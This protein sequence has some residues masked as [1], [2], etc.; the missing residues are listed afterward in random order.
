MNPSAASSFAEHF[1]DLLDKILATH[2][3]A[4]SPAGLSNSALIYCCL[5]PS[6]IKLASFLSQRVL[7]TLMKLKRFHGAS[8][9]YGIK[10]WIKRKSF[11]SSPDGWPKS[12]HSPLAMASSV[13]GFRPVADYPVHPVNPV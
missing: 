4:F 1:L 2:S 13:S 3:H 8:R 12:Y 5:N 10:R 6:R 11:S 9:I 7:L